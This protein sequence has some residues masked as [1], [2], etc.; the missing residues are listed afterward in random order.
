[1]ISEAFFS[2]VDGSIRL[3]RAATPAML[4]LDA[5]AVR[6]DCLCYLMERLSLPQQTGAAVS[7][8]CASV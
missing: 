8:L 3:Q 1:L 2:S 6:Q 4:T 7:S 5:R